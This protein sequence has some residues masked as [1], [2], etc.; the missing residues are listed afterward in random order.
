[1]E[2]NYNYHYK[3]RQPMETVLIIKNFFYK[4]GFIIKEKEITEEES[5]T[6][7]CSL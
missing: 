3:E 6:W 4:K 5:K 7:S 2:N 1:M